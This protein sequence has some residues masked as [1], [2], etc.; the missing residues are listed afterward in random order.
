MR[1]LSGP[2]LHSMMNFND[3]SPEVADVMMAVD[4]EHLSSSAKRGHL[5]V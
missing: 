5:D 1:I 2:N 3:G 4:D